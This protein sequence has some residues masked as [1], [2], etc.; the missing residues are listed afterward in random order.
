MNIRIPL[1]AV[2]FIIYTLAILGGAFGIS[3]GVFEWRDDEGSDTSS[4]ERRIDELER[5]SKAGPTQ[6]E[7]DAQ[8]CAAA[9]E[10]AGEAAKAPRE[11]DRIYIGAPPLPQAIE[12]Q[13]NRHC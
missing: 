6:A 12:E 3:Y 11:L 10:A 2:A 4:I 5:E 8:K 7:L 1:R 9:L 13:I